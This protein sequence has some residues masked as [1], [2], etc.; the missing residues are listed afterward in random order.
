MRLVR[1]NPFKETAFTR[2]PLNNLFN[3]SFFNTLP[4][5]DNDWYPAVDI[6][7]GKNDVILNIEL[8]GINKD[9]IS[10]NIEDKVL[11]IK[12]ERKF[13]S[14]E[15]KDCYLRKERSYGNFERS[16]NL[17]DDVLTDGVKADFKDG[18]LKVTLKK[19][20]TKKQ[21]RQITIN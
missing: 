8:P 19:D 10:M 13:E 5:K 16:F 17:S 18:V 6:L 3:D 20:T 11:T 21:V 7:N 9:N 12:G 1:Y 14:E 15:K 2:N 4:D